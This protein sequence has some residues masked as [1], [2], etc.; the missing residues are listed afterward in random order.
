MTAIAHIQTFKLGIRVPDNGHSLSAIFPVY[1]SPTG[2]F[3]RE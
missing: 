3:G 1:P 2:H